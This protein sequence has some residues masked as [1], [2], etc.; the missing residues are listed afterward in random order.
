MELENRIKSVI[1]QSVRPA[2]QS[3]GGDIDFVSFEA[4]SGLLKVLLKGACGTCPF[5]QETL[6]AQ[7]ETVL[8]DEFPEIIRVERA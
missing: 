4:G 7:V 1:D 8:K 2:L 5:A 6:R 3:H